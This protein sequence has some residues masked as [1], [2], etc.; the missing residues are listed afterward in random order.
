[1]NAKSVEEDK[2]LVQKG[3]QE[4]VDVVKMV[5]YLSNENER[6]QEKGLKNVNNEVDQRI[7]NIADHALSDEPTN[8]IISSAVRAAIDDTSGK[9]GKGK[10]YRQV[11]KIIRQNSKNTDSSK[12]MC[13][14][15]YNNIL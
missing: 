15:H 9:E 3:K 13:V 5:M 1:M 11:K 12:G 10:F 7:N 4:L 6:E 8:R 14:L 2:K